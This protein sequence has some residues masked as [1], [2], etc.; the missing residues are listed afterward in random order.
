MR[1]APRTYGHFICLTGLAVTLLAG[2]GCTSSGLNRARSRYYS[3][4]FEEAAGTFDERPVRSRDQILMLMERGAAWQ[5]AGE[6]QRAINDWLEAADRMRELDYI[7]LSEQASSLIIS[8]AT[9]TYAGW[10]YERA[11]LHAHTAKSFFALQQ[12]HAAAVE[13]RLIAY[14]LEDLNAFPDDPYTRYVAATAFELIRDYNGARIEFTKADELTPHIRINPVTGAITPGTNAPANV[15]PPD[16]EFIAFIGIGRAPTFNMGPPGQNLRWGSNPYVEV[17]QG[18][19]ILGRSYTLMTTTTLAHETERRIAAIQAARTVT[20]IIIKESISRAVEE[21]NTLL[22]GILRIF[23]YAT[24]APDTRSW[25][26]LP[27]WLQVARVPLADDTTEL[28]LHFKTSAG[29]TIKTMRIH[30]EK[31]P[32]TDGKF[33]LQARAW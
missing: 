13:A 15:V 8:D 31:M 32:R 25:Q 9:K 7:R 26:T 33:I 27:N 24:E 23:L 14:G 6:H 16:Q 18:D 4:S 28:E 20:R 10:P 1:P 29:T 2:T 22:G 5:A 12:W 11:L 3:G 19:Q 30:P 17:R 21:N